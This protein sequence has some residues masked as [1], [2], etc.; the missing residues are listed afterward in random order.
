ML[1]PVDFFI[2]FIKQTKTLLFERKQTIERKAMT[3]AAVKP[4]HQDTLAVQVVACC[5]L[6]GYP[7]QKREGDINIVGIKGMNLNNRQSLI[8]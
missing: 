4:L 5:E 1:Y 6:R 3:Q 7:L 8:L 2:V